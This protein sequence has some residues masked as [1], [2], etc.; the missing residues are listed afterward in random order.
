ML[1]NIG[2]GVDT[3]AETVNQ[4]TST[5]VDTFNS[6]SVEDFTRR[7]A[8]RKIA[9]GLNLK[10]LANYL[11]TSIRSVNVTATVLGKQNISK[12]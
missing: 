9:Y 8:I 2:S 5:L 4:D 6:P 10:F 12:K 1:A 7:T 11:R 3:Y